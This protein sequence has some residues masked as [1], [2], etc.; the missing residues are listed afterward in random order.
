MPDSQDD[1]LM[2]TVGGKGCLVGLFAACQS[3]F[4][5]IAPLGYEDD[6]GFHLLNDEQRQEAHPP[7]QPAS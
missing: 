3:A 1:I 7:S 5:H 6:T 4:C 2:P